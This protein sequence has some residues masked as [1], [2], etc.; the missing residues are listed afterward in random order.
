MKIKLICVGKLKET[1]F[2][3]AAEEYL[4]RLKRF[5]KV[6]ILEIPEEIR[7]EAPSSSEIEKALSEVSTSSLFPL[8]SPLRERWLFQGLASTPC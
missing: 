4:K 8:H 7:H 1:F 3:D 2:K 5:H 6:E